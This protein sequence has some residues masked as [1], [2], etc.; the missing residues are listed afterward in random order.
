[1]LPI[2]ALIR[3]DVIDEQNKEIAE[4]KKQIEELKNWKI[5]CVLFRCCQQCMVCG[6]MTL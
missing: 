1:M 4:L 5:I 3:W 2:K 6:V